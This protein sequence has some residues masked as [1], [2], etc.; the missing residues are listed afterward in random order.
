ML[1]DSSEIWM[2]WESKHCHKPRPELLK[3]SFHDYQSMPS[4]FLK[5]NKKQTIQKK[6]KRAQLLDVYRRV[7]FWAIKSFPLAPSVVRRLG[8]IVFGEELI[9]YQCPVMLC[10]EW[11]ASVWWC[12]FFFLHTFQYSFSDCFSGPDLLWENQPAEAEQAHETDIV[13][14]EDPLQV[15]ETC[16]SRWAYGRCW[17]RRHHPWPCCH[18]PDWLPGG[19]EPLLSWKP[20]WQQMSGKVMSP[21]VVRIWDLVYWTEHK[22]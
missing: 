10:Q 2:C 22:Q 6:K 11:W 14:Q 16:S 15:S 19:V 18:P 12:G 8:D 20:Q 9:V 4:A 1:L 13:P 21:K 5:V 17:P 3:Q 7:W